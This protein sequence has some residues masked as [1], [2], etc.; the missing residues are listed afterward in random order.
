M[1]HVKGKRGGRKKKE[2]M[3]VTCRYVSRIDFSGIRYLST[4]G[5]ALCVDAKTADS[6]I[7]QPFAYNRR[8]GDIRK[9][10]HNSTSRQFYRCR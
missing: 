1:G 10:E 9:Q 5:S 4:I 6:P 7:F 3:I 8:I 2:G